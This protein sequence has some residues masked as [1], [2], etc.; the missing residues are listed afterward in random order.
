MPKVLT[1]LE[2]DEDTKQRIESFVMHGTRIDPYGNFTHGGE[3]LVREVKSIHVTEE[4]PAG[5]TDECY[6]FPWK[7]QSG[8]SVDPFITIEDREANLFALQNCEPAVKTRHVYGMMIEAEGQHW[9][10]T[11]REGGSSEDWKTCDNAATEAVRI[12]GVTPLSLGSLACE[13]KEYGAATEGEFV[14]TVEEK[15]MLASVPWC[16]EL[17]DEQSPCREEDLALLE[18]ARD[19]VRD[20]AKE[21][22]P[23]P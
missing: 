19:F 21:A 12:H 13:L 16:S 20:L 3:G 14:F 11:N 8:L 9:I 22:A 18:K 7:G 15:P 4:K 10:L 2:I 6:P 1:I 23:A 5:V 17:A